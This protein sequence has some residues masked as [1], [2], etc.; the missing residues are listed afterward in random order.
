LPSAAKAVATNFE[1]SAEEAAAVQA[2]T[3]EVFVNQLSPELVEIAS[4]PLLKLNPP[5]AATRI[6][7]SAEEAT[8]TQRRFG[9]LF[10]IQ[11][12]PESTDV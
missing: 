1:P 7:P 3:G 9:A 2:K 5:G 8:E 4:G 10:E 12:S 6:F 11:V